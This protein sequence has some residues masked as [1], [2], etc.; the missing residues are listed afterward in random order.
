MVVHGVEYCEGVMGRGCVV[1]SGCVQ[2]PR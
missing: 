2:C 1:D